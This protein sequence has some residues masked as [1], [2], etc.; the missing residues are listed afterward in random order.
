MCQFLLDDKH[1]LLV[2]F[3][4]INFIYPVKLQGMT[5]NPCTRQCFRHVAECKNVSRYKKFSRYY[6]C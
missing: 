6:E 1:F 2:H 4:D 3:L 5:D